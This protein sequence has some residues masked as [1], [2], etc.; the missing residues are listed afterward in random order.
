LNVVEVGGIR[1]GGGDLTLI[2][3]PCVVESED[4]ALAAAVRL[5]D[6]CAKAGIPLIYKSSFDKA[7]RSSVKSF[8]GPGRDEGLAILA[9]VGRETGLPVLSDVHSA[10]DIE[11]AKDSL[12]ILQIPAFLSRQTDLLTAAAKSAKPVNV[13]KGQFL[14]PWDMG[15]VVEKLESAG[16]RGILL[17]ER[18]N[19]FGYNNLV[20]DMRS[21][22]VLREYG[23]PV[24]FD[25]THSVQLPGG[26]GTASGGDR[27]FI[28][29]LAR[30]AAAVGVD[31]L[32]IECHEDPDNAPC[33]GPNML[34]L[35][36][37]PDILKTVK[38]I[39]ENVRENLKD[40]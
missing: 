40:G 33:D 10:E 14:A 34:P 9:K 37:L 38:A 26:Q 24:V 35:G 23:W 19:S 25:V 39:H 1:I 30:A 8:R 28:P 12:D 7:N 22:A 2:A 11:A 29:P 21:L 31:A 13:K 4:K 20:A 18:G 5:K 16:A 36:G 27:K 32:F 15:N 3:G 17:T 6:I